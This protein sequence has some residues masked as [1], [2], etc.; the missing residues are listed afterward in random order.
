MFVD[1]LWKIGG[2]IICVILLFVV[3]LKMNFARQDKIIDQVVRTRV[4]LF[5]EQARE[6]GYISEVMVKELEASLSA[7]GLEYEVSFEHLSKRFAADESGNLK[8]Y[9]DGSY[10][11]DIYELIDT[12]IDYPLK[13]GDFLFVEVRSSSITKSQAMNHLFGLPG[14]PG[15]YFKSGGIVRY[16]NS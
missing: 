11:E 12:G 3:P 6:L 15:I 13:M 4:M 2:I 9:Y 14:G 7:T 5:S 16:G 1:S 8:A 10:E